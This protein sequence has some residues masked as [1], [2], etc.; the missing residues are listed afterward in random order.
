[1][2]ADILEDAG[3]E[4]ATAAHGNRALAQIRTRRSALLITD[5]TIPFMTGLERA[6]AIRADQ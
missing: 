3:H 6:Q 4:V 1:M 5:F 2:L